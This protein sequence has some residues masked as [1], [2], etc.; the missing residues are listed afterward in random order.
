[1]RLQHDDTSIATHPRT[2]GTSRRGRR[3][4]CAR[5]RSWTGR[6]NL[7][8]STDSRLPG[9]VTAG[10]RR[11]RVSEMRALPRIARALVVDAPRGPLP[12]ILEHRHTR[13]ARPRHGSG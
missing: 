6:A 11:T 2:R 8:R 13:R 4:S 7:S 5:V 12:A 9:F 3:V 1:M 10:T